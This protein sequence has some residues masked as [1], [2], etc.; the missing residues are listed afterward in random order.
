MF[1]PI[2]YIGTCD[3]FPENISYFKEEL[4]TNTFKI[5]SDLKEIQ[6]II[7][8][9]VD[10]EIL[11]LKLLNTQIRTSNEG[12]KLSG[13]KLLVEI[14]FTYKIKYLSDLKEKY[15]YLLKSSLT[16]V[17]YIVLPREYENFKIEE[18]IRKKALGVKVYIEDIYAQ[19]RK[20][21]EIYI[22]KLVLV[23]AFIKEKFLYY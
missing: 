12:Q 19:K 16:K 3:D 18:I 17:F 4:I 15:L 22:R 14:K 23:N 5:K 9:S 21:K 11:T 8:V 2:D 6:K 10:Y 20:E 7:S 1:S 13:K